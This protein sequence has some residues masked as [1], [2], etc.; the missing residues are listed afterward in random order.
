MDT[1][2]VG[3]FCI[4]ILSGQIMLSCLSYFTIID[5]GFVNIISL[6]V[7]YCQHGAFVLGHFFDTFHASNL[8]S[9]LQKRRL[10]LLK[11]E[12]LKESIRNGKKNCIERLRQRHFR[13]FFIISLC[14]FTFF[15]IFVG[16]SKNVLRFFLPR[17]V[18][19]GIVLGLLRFARM[20]ER[21][22]H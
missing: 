10:K 19:Y 18:R 11:I 8:R 20:M 14:N 13:N 21:K 4:I 5:S 9:F 15:M 2:F 3:R 7:S 22:R 16:E 1:Q 17:N 6:I 12:R